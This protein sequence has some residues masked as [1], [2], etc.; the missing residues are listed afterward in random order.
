MLFEPKDELMFY[1]WEGKDMGTY[2][3]LKYLSK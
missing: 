1:L 2:L 3:K